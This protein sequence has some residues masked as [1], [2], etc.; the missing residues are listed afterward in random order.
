VAV[1]LLASFNVLPILQG[2]LLGAM[3][4]VATKVLSP[5][6]ARRSIDIEVIVLIAAALGLA[7]AMQTSGLAEAIAGGLVDLLGP[8]GPIG[9]LLALMLATLLLTEMVTN[10]AAALLMVPIAVATAQSVGLDP[11]GV[12]IAVAVAASAS[13]LTPIG[14]QTNMM[15]YGPGGYRFTDYARLGWVLSVIVL[16]VTVALTPVLWP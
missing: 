1:V 9:V 12:A 13:F 5:Q 2:S 15:V 6:E 3:A 7:T 11:R 14:Y 4:L 10:N 8:F 16:V